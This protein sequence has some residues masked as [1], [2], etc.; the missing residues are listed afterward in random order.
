M[1]ELGQ[2][3][4]GTVYRALDTHLDRYIALKV[5]R[6][7]IKVDAQAHARFTQEAKAASA[8]NHPNI[9][10]IYDVG[11]E[12]GVDYIA[13]EY[14]A[15]TTLDPLLTGLPLPVDQTLNYCIQ[16][17]DALA[18]AHRAGIVHRDLKPGNVMVNERGLV[19]VLDFGL[20]KLTERTLSASATSD[21]PTLPISPQTIA[22]QTVGTPSY[23]SPEQAEGREIDARSDIFSFGIMLYQ[24]LS[25]VLPFTGTSAFAVLASVLRDEPKPVAEAAPGISLALADVV[26]RCLRKDPN[27]RY[28]SIE[29]A[30][31]ALEHERQQ[32]NLERAGSVR[33]SSVQQPAVPSVP[34]RRRIPLKAIMVAVFLI[35]L[36]AAGGLWYAFNRHPAKPTDNT[37]VRLTSDEGL[38]TTPAISP[39]GKLLAYASDRSGE[40]TLDLWVMQI[41]SS[42]QP[43]R[44]TKEGA[45]ATSPVFSPD[46]TRIAFRSERNGGAIY[47]TPA[48]SLELA[49]EQKFVAAEG[50]RPRF[51]PDGAKIVY[52]TAPR[53]NTNATRPDW[54]K[55]FMVDLS[56]G[57]NPVPVRADFAA[58][59]NPIFTPDGSHILFIGTRTP[60]AKQS[61]HWWVTPLDGGEP[62]DTGFAASV[63]GSTDQYRLQIPIAW[64]G[65]RVIYS[66]SDS[67]AADVRE[68]EISPRDWQVSG[69]P[70]KL[71]FG[72]THDEYPSFSSD[73]RLVFA[74]LA[75]NIDIYALPM[76][77]NNGALTGELRRVTRT[78][79]VDS[80][81]DI[82]ADGRR[83]VFL[84]DR[85]GHS[86]VWSHDFDTGAEKQLSDS[87]AAKRQPVITRDGQTV[88]FAD[89][90]EGPTSIYTVPFTGGPPRRACERCG[91]QSG[92]APDGKHLLVTDYAKARNPI[93]D[94]DVDT[95]QTREVLRHPQYSLFPRSFSPDGNWI[96]LSADRGA[97]GIPIAIAPYRPGNPPPESEW[98][99]LTDGKSQ[100]QYPR[101]SPDGNT[102]YF[103]SDRDGH[104]AILSQRLDPQTKHPLGKPASLYVFSSS[105]RFP[106]NML[107]ISV[108]QDK[109]VFSL[110]ERTG[111]IWMLRP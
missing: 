75:S 70:H 34:P 98:I 68:I 13:M 83:L 78:A 35:A 49:G 56:A 88:A 10:H 38:D 96:S 85:T 71:T 12:N 8:L 24:M 91:A 41:G 87:P 4:M 36:L 103:V 55:M 110:E 111:S 80:V 7:D 3:G 106:E 81:R 105:L 65:G 61:S 44:R 28:Q 79:S 37:P 59:I 62:V 33:I 93:L 94:L 92:W 69:E 18:A 73:G 53:S 72:T 9:V 100:D 51:S 102:I 67:N 14:I 22:G 58:A 15:G 20:A 43:F 84:T 89:D 74:S 46:G 107:W 2:G 5:L 6:S 66:R 40:G 17:A 101:W 21:A 95:G 52:Y 39:D 29:D 26:T 63:S 77:T 57:K 82:S 104:I 50:R 1:D 54:G 64:H 11:E 19:K 60:D 32:R 27:L 90:V 16:I 45:D 23:M 25:G 97:A 109:I 108:A 99:F 48:I 47:I 30:Q 42:A 86:E 31:S 76:N